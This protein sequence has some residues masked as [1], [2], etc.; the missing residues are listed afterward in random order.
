MAPFAN[1]PPEVMALANET[2]AAV[3]SGKPVFAGPLTDQAGAVKVA[4]GKSMDDGALSSM[5]WL[6]Q[7]IDGKLT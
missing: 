1:M 4:A 5:Q 3:A 7:G 2:K 6:V